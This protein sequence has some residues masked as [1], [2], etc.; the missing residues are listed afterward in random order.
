M[1]QL[2]HDMRFGVRSLRRSPGYTLPV[3]AILGLGVGAIAAVFSLV[4]GILWQPLPYERPEQLHFLSQSRHGSQML[5]ASAPNFRDLRERT[6]AFADIAAYSPDDLIASGAAEPE[7]IDAAEVTVNLPAL[8][9]LEPILGRLFAADEEGTAVALLSHAFWRRQFDADS[10][11]GASIELDGRDYEVVGV[12]PPVQLLPEGV[13]VWVPIRLDVPDW[14]T[15]RGIDWIIMIGRLRDGIGREEAR[16]ELDTLGAALA[17]EYPDAN[18]GESYAPVPLMEEMVGDTRTPLLAMWGAVCAVL[19]VVCANLG[20]LGAARSLRRQRELSIRHALGSGR[21]RLARQLLVEGGLLGLGGCV[22]GVAFGV[23]ILRWLLAVAPPDTPRIAHVGFDLGAA[24]VALAAGL[25]AGIGA[26]LVPAIRAGSSRGQSLAMESSARATSSR[27]RGGFVVAQIAG[28][29]CL[30]VVAA[31]LIQSL[32]R[33]T[34]V[35]PGFESDGLLTVSLPVVNRDFATGGE[36][37]RHYEALLEAVRPLPGVSSADMVN[38]LPLRSAGPTFS[39]EMRT[40]PAETELLAGFRVATPGYFDTL[41]IP[42]LEGR[43]FLPEE[44]GDGPPVV[45]VDAAF[46]ERFFPGRSALGQEI[47]LLDAWR[48]VV[49]VVGSV[50]DSGLASPASAR[51]YVPMAQGPRQGMVL[52]ARTTGDP[53]SLLPSLRTAIR[54]VAPEQALAGPAPMSDWIRRSVA[55]DRFLTR[56][57]VSFAAVALL[58]AAIGM[59]GLLGTSVSERSR[60]IGVRIAVGGSARRIRRMILGQGMALTGVGLGVGLLAAWLVARS[61]G[62]VLYEVEPVDPVAYTLVPLVLGVVAS[63]AAWLPARRA[64]RV[65][66]VEALRSE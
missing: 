5:W 11:I 26:S 19:L 32:W 58:L 1:S 54:R 17:S 34:R 23:A 61:L 40:P 21:G 15:R 60:E 4:N 62:P 39:F 41:G 43:S 6:R 45:I 2:L 44:D 59:Y 46:A 64:S 35:D 20:S 13:D 16:A 47:E 66:P 56:L 65:D 22:L 38:T 27:L 10:A 3:L 49:G 24:A 37:V 50:H 12:L 33:L 51:M 30:V 57:L 53:L 63:L 25:V 52:V 28:S 31:L 36:R 42:V 7:S 14:R 9:G 29:A 48:R 18:E 55:G 8:L